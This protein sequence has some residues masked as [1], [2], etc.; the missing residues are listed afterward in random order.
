MLRPIQARLVDVRRKT[1]YHHRQKAMQSN[2]F[3]YDQPGKTL[4]KY[5]SSFIIKHFDKTF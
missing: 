5:A 1:Q 3:Y 4:A 2:L